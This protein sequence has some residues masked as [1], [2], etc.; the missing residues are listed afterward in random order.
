MADEIEIQPWLDEDGNKLMDFDESPFSCTDC[1]CC[2]IC[3]ELEKDPPDGYKRGTRFEIEG[4]PCSG[5]CTDTPQTFSIDYSD[6]AAENPG[7]ETCIWR[8]YDDDSECWHWYVITPDCEVY[9]WAYLLDCDSS[10]SS[11]SSSS[12]GSSSSG[13]SS[14]GSSSSGSSSS[15][16]GSS[17]SGSGSSSSGSGS[18]SSGSGSSSSGSG[19]SSSGS[20]SSSDS[21][22][23]W[24]CQKIWH[25]WQFGPLQLPALPCGMTS[26]QVMGSFTLEQLMNLC[27]DVYHG[28][29]E[30]TYNTYR[31]DADGNVVDGSIIQDTEYGRN[32]GDKLWAANIG[33][34]NAEGDITYGDDCDHCM[35][36]VGFWSGW[37]DFNAK[38]V[39]E[40]TKVDSPSECE[41]G[42]SVQMPRTSQGDS[43]EMQ[44]PSP[45]E[46]DLI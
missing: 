15:G 26:T 12:S 43:L 30:Y 28:H 1:P 46:D 44:T 23:G 3:D 36:Q 41:G 13:S 45:D 6:Y 9:E 21:P 34:Y 38:H 32:E 40:T 29:S 16:S 4:I 39:M 2:T 35:W 7:W 31:L 37:D 25:V 17:S 24:Y 11:S 18:S 5:Y 22:E 27:V 14:S 33:C 10:S 8:E 42:R 20:S 19:S